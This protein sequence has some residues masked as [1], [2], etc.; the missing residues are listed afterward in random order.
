MNE[1]EYN[2][3]YIRS[4]ISETALNKA[5][6]GARFEQLVKRWLQVDPL[7]A[8]EFDKV[9]TWS[10]FP[11]NDGA[12]DYGIDL[13]ARKA[14][15]EDYV[16][17]QCKFYDPEHQISK[18]DVDTFLSASG[19]SFFADGEEKRFTD[20]LFISSTN[21][22]SST[23]E[24]TIHGQQPPVTRIGLDE[25]R[26]SEV[27]WSS[28]S[29]DSIDTLQRSPAKS[30]RPHQERAMSDVLKGFE[31]SDRGRLIMACGTGKTY[32]SL[33]IAE[34]LTHGEGNVL[35]LVPSISLLNQTLRE[36]AAECKYNYAAFAICSDS[37]ASSRRN[38]DGDSSTV[39]DTV[40]PATTDVARLVKGYEAAE[41]AGK[42]LRLFFS[43]Y[44]SID[45]VAEFQKKTGVN[46]NLIIC[47]EA[48]RTT[49]V[50]LAGDDESAFVRVHND[51]F[52]H[53]DHRLYMT[54]TPRIYQAKTKAKAAEVDA[55]LCSMDDETVYGPEF[56]RLGFGAAVA[57]DLLS[58]YKVL[59]LAV[60]EKF[61][62]RKL[63]RLLSNEEN[64]LSLDDAVKIVGCLNG[65]AKRTSSADE[66]FYFTG[67]EAPMRRAVAFT[68]SIKNSKAF[69]NMTEEIQQELMADD[70]DGRPDVHLQHVDGKQNAL[71]RNEKIDWLKSAPENETRILSNA[72]CLS[73][74]IDVPALDAVMFLNPRKSM[75][76]IIQ[77][78][79]RVMRKA[80][81]KRYGYI[82]LPIGI[83]SDVPPEKALNDNK[84]YQVVWDV[85]QALRAHDDRMDNIINKVELNKKKPKQINIIGVGT[86]GDSDDGDE[87]ASGGTEKYDQME[88]DLPSLE[89]W[90]D[91][92]FA[93]LVQKCGSKRYWE[94]W[95]KDIAEITKRI[96]D[97][98]RDRCKDPDV[99]TAFHSFLAELRRDLNPSITED[100]AIEMLAE[101]MITE[102]VFNALF[103]NYEFA[104]QNPVSKAMDDMLGYLRDEN[105][106]FDSMQNFY[107]S[108]R[109]RAAGIDNAEGKQK[110]V[111]EL[112]NSFFKNA[113]PRQADRL[114][115]VYTPVEVVD[116]ILNSVAYVLM[117]K[118]GRELGDSDVTLLDPF[119]G[120]GTFIVQLLRS[121]LIP[122]EKLQDRYLHGIYA[123]ELVL[124][125]YYIAAV[126]IEETYHDVAGEKAYVPFPGIVLTDSF[127]LS[128]SNKDSDGV[129]VVG[130]SAFIQENTE[131]AIRERDADI[132]VIVGNPPY[133]TGQKSENDQNKNLKYTHLDKVIAETYVAASTSTSNSRVYDSYIRALRWASDRIGAQG[134]VGF[135]TNGAFL[136]SSSA[137]GLRKHLL[138]EFTSVYVFNLR[139]AARGSGE[140]RR[141]E[142]GNVFGNGSRT[143]VAITILVRVQGVPRD[144]VV[145]YYDI[146][147]YLSR[148]D[149]LRKIRELGSIENM[150][151][152]LIEPNEKNDWLNQRNSRFTSLLQLATT[153]NNS[154]TDSIFGK[155]IAAG[156]TSS[157]DAWAYNFSESEVLRNM[158]VMIDFYNAERVQCEHDPE[159]ADMD[160]T[161]IS[162]SR[163]LLKLL[164]ANKEII[165][166]QVAY[167]TMYRPFC[168]K[169]LAYGRQILEMPS[170]WDEFFPTPEAQ[171]LVIG[172]SRPPLKNGLSVLI[173]NSMQDLHCL[174]QEA[175]VPLY[176]YSDETKKS[177]RQMSM[178]DVSGERT[179]QAVRKDT[180]SKE[181]LKR[182]QKVYGKDITKDDIF[183]YIYVVLQHPTYLNTYAANLAKEFPRIPLVDGFRE[184]VH[185]GRMLADLH[186]NYEHA[187]DPSEV[188]GLKVDVSEE[189]YCVEKM[190]FAKNGKDIDKSTII[191]N[192]YI[193]VSGI[194]QR[195]Y[196][197]V[198]N[199]RSAIEWIMESY[200]IKTDK[201]SG[202]VDDP[203]TYSDNPRYILDLLISI[204]ALSLKTEDLK[205]QLPEYK[206]I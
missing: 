78:V 99:A 49:G 179:R 20:R 87:T 96:I 26:N 118:L 100:D 60:D 55:V 28:F 109:E 161:K 80:D 163:G 14:G 157:R 17:V 53:A 54:A 196:D 27:D 35:F 9:W 51:E 128:E 24:N 95:A 144:D 102:P 186:L 153:K 43:T 63:Q 167:K 198:I 119:T 162:W 56:H 188:P 32:T 5:M 19:K 194:P 46:F 199:G 114:G 135:V 110:I 130:N 174:E 111:I 146:G 152:Q 91:S 189:N 81:G 129:T 155:E 34:A 170:K 6:K 184:Y 158:G 140:Q 72:R 165:A 94:T 30:P 176:T 105:G 160:P 205:A 121:N 52:L 125:A 147:D 66:K 195:A 123:N 124:L 201:D 202:I 33:Q 206:E 73:E 86:G 116:F 159:R 120:T 148:A 138:E 136:D 42:P 166:P 57:A 22:W 67:D 31:A 64:E 61:V 190:R 71:E 193:T 122:R 139:G 101:H 142:S 25:L 15:T 191:V 93:K 84:R 172:I 134:V 203:N 131:R 50:T 117:D 40:I 143:S 169:Y 149:K 4:N 45:V 127:A 62:D 85:L 74:G 68:S 200:R 77:A 164:N 3:E 187:V 145:H 76:D 89:D 115:I 178:T 113:L 47:D 177:A 79:G 88:M 82:I 181:M 44:Q 141:K 151:W 182:F 154:G 133:S 69:V 107:Q 137:D 106:E 75:V 13:V 58:D 132:T 65:L 8:S 92:I 180:I 10:E 70:P 103:D 90:K 156:V 2:F 12:H 48:H 183:F 112:Y 192:P 108:V 18:A 168:K 97:R 98:L 29:P 38:D 7:Y 175:G 197:Y 59:V 41:R 39:S 16:A 1:P 185:I 11:Y 21:K 104:A 36:W 37:R 83:P 173:S 204:I 150:E 171:N 23:A 126:N